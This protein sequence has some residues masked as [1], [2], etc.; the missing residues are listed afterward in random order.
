MLATEK[1][2]HIIVGTYITAKNVAGYT[3]QLLKLYDTRSKTERNHK[4]KAERLHESSLAVIKDTEFLLNHAKIQELAEAE[5][6]SIEQF[7]WLGSDLDIKKR[8][9]AINFIMKMNKDEKDREA[10]K[11]LK[12]ASVDYGIE[13]AKIEYANFES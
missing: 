4:R 9:R 6:D 5:S 12:E 1:T 10:K 8:T 11:L 13:D 7:L 2:F 3:E